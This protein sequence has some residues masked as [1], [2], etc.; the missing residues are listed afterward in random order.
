VALTI[1]YLKGRSVG[2]ALM[3]MGHL[4]FVAHFLALVLNF[5]PQR[6][7]PALLRHLF[8]RQVTL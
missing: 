7:Q 1:P 8:R 4:L 6:D 3:V 2:G 5:G